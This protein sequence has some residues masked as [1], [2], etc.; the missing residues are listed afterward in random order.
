MVSPVVTGVHTTS[1]TTNSFSLS[2]LVCYNNGTW[3]GKKCVCQ[4]GYFGV[5]CQSLVYSFPIEIPE[6]LNA[7]VTVIVK[8]IYRN[9]TKDL[10]NVSSPAYQNFAELFKQQMDKVYAGDD[11]SEYREVIIRQLSNGSIVVQNDVVLEASYTSEYRAL[12]NNLKS[13]VEAKIKNETSVIYTDISK[14]QDSI[15]CYSRE[16]TD[17]TDWKLGFDPDEQCARGAAVGYGQYYYVD[18]L[19]G[20]PACVN[21]CTLGT[22]SQLN[23]NDGE[24]QLQSSGPRC[25]CP[26]TDTHWY[27][28]ETCQL[29]L[30]KNLV[31]G[32]VGAVVAVLLVMVVILTVF[33]GRSQR[34]LHRQEYD[35]SHEWQKE[36]IPG[37]FK[38]TGVWEGNN[39]KEDKFGLEHGYS[40]FRPSLEKVDPTTE[41]HI[42]KPEVVTTTL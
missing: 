5:Q 24:C 38:N 8:V 23:C 15:L 4:Q 19:D 40:H 39:L 10:N 7:T 2:P 16:D 36:G 33:L 18:E 14:C 1:M 11:L 22:K 25:L 32:I 30:N 42:Q 3:N 6:V 28:G 21:K 9:F 26:N 34:K 35:P 41:L 27:W 20:K 17:V 37:T 12:F 13:I 29:S 31:Y